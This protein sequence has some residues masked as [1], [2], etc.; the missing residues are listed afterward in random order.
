MSKFWER[1]W[2]ACAVVHACACVFGIVGNYL[3]ICFVSAIFF[4]CSIIA[5]FDSKNY[6]IELAKLDANV[7]EL[8][9]A[10]EGHGHGE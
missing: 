8:V 3:G 10:A 9:A 2:I 6:R 5:Y 1:S 4:V 7:K